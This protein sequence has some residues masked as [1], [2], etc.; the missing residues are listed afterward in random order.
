MEASS[1]DYSHRAPTIQK[2]SGRRDG[3]QGGI[4]TSNLSTLRRDVKGEVLSNA[5]I[6]YDLI[7]P[8]T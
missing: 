8:S 3:R 2:S 4:A 6:K 5:H 7:G 1:E